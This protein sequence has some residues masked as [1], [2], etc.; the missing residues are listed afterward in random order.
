[1]QEDT[2]LKVKELKFLSEL[3]QDFDI[4]LKRKSWF[5]QYTFEKYTPLTK[6]RINIDYENKRLIIDIRDIDNE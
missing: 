2:T 3:P 6:D 4:V 5:W 1:M